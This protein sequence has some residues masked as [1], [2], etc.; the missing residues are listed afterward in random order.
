MANDNLSFL[1]VEAYD[2]N[3]SGKHSLHNTSHKIMFTRCVTV[4]DLCNLIINVLLI[5]V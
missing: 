5:T 1:S 3:V 2:S 4:C